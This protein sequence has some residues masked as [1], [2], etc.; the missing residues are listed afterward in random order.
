MGYRSLQTLAIWC[1]TTFF[2]KE[3]GSSRPPGRRTQEVAA[4]WA[5]DSC[6]KDL[7]SSSFGF[8]RCS[9]GDG[10]RTFQVFE[11]VRL[12]PVDWGK[13]TNGFGRSCTYGIMLSLV[14]VIT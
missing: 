10:P 9:Q 12:E 6:V 2:S 4:A 3:Y 13:A 11:V 5:R 14:C 7:V 8:T 1:K